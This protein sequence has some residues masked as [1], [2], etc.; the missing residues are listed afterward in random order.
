MSSKTSEQDSLDR[1]ARHSKYAFGTNKKT[2][3][4]SF[5][6]FSRHIKTGSILELGPAEGVMTDYLVNLKQN[7]TVVDGAEIFCKEI[8]KRYPQVTVVN[9]LFEEYTPSER[10]NNII[11]GHVLEH[12]ED[13]VALLTRAREWL[14]EDG[15]I[16]AA[17]PNNRSI[18]RQVGVLLGLLNFEEEMSDWDHYHGHRRVYSPETFRSEFIKANLEIEVFGG[19]WL[20]PLSNAQIESTWS[21]SLLDAFMKIGERYPDIAGTI[22]IIAKR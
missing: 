10:F 17:V 19:Y 16:M 3:S 2:I 20:K 7:L 1:I 6:I 9:S 5:K 8:K 22:Y 4:Y 13:P 12:V 18:H 15:Y 21:D 11:L 14:T